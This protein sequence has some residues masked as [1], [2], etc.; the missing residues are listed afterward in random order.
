MT[1]SAALTLDILT[2]MAFTLHPPCIASMPYVLEI[3]GDA[4]FR[5][6]A[7]RGVFGVG[8]GPFGRNDGL[9]PVFGGVG[10]VHLQCCGGD[11]WE[12]YY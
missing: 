3:G 9:A 4:A 12:G 7:L 8:E 11:F 1:S 6:F 2:D 10:S 5:L